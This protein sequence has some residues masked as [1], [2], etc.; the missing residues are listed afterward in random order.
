MSNPLNL[1]APVDTLA[2]EFTREFDAPREVV[3]RAWTDPVRLAQWWG[4]HGFS[5]PVC[6][7]DPRPGG[8]DGLRVQRIHRRR[9]IEDA[10][11]TAAGGNDDFFRRV[12]SGNGK[13]RAAG[14][15]EQG[16]AAESADEHGWRV[17]TMQQAMC[18]RRPA[19]TAASAQR[20]QFLLHE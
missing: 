14:E 20:L 6:E 19:C 3:F 8:A 18:R 10:L 5:N 17:S 12:L 1:T 13:A 9:R 7:L 2:M 15:H 4:P 11:F 16:T